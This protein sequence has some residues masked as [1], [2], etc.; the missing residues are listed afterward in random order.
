MLQYGPDV[1]DQEY[2]KVK[3]FPANMPDIWKAQ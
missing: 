1:F 3:S 2:F